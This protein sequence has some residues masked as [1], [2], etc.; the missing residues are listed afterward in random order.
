MQGSLESLFHGGIVTVGLVR[1]T[2]KAFHDAHA[3]QAF[4]GHDRRIGQL[5]LDARAAFLDAP[6]K[7]ESDQEKNRHQTQNEQRQTGIQCQ[8]NHDR[9]DQ[10]YA[11]AEEHGEIAGQHGAHL[12][13]VTG[14]PRDYI[15][16]TPVGIKVER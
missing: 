16:D 5:I 15:A 8:D 14:Q 13:H 1:F 2:A 6:A 11:L 4:F 7:Q 3:L 10:R 9:T 12:S